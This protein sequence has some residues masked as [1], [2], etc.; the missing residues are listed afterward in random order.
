MGILRSLSLTPTHNICK[1]FLGHFLQTFLEK[2]AKVS[3]EP[4][5]T[6]L[7]VL[8]VS[9]M[10][11]PQPITDKIANQSHPPYAYWLHGAQEEKWVLLEMTVKNAKSRHPLE[12]N[13]MHAS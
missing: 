6:T 13:F 3:Q 12:R 5:K 11:L 1:E 2:W 9:Q 10:P 8:L 7:Q 4:Q